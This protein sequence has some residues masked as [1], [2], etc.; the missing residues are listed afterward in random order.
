MAH[1]GLWRGRRQGRIRA[2]TIGRY[3]KGRG[4]T[5]RGEVASFFDFRQ[6]TL[7]A[8]LV[9]VRATVGAGAQAN[10]TADV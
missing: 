1:S 3:R 6:S 9:S 8:K 10:L 7:D 2:A 5:S 4:A